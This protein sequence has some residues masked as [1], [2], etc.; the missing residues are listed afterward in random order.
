M[1]KVSSNWVKVNNERQLLNIPFTK[2]TNENFVNWD[3]RHYRLISK[4][5]YDVSKAGGDYIFAFFPLF[6]LVWRTTHLPPV[7]ILLLNYLLYA[8][9]LY[10]ILKLFSSDDLTSLILSFSIPGL[11]IFLIPYS[12]AVFFITVAVGFYGFIKKKYTIFFI[13]FFLAAIDRP[14]YTILAL[15]IV[16]VEFISLMHKGYYKKFI[17]NLSLRLLPL[18]AGTVFVS[19][20]QYFQGSGDFF[21]FIKVQK[22]WDNVLAIPHNIIDWSHEGF[23]INIGVITLIFLPLLAYLIITVYRK[24]SDSL[25]RNSTDSELNSLYYLTLLSTLYIIGSTLFIIFFRGGSL[26]CLFRFTI[27]TPFFPV[28]VISFSQML[29]KIEPQIRFFML[30]C[31]FLAGLF[32]LAMVDYSTYWSFA[33]LG[34]FIL[35]AT[36]T[37]WVFRKYQHKLIYKT[38]LYLNFFVNIIWTS[39]LF[40]AYIND[41]WIFA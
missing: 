21:R 23:G 7:G 35:T 32:I 9:G 25:S 27:C 34:F 24:V 18:I 16:C 1:G 26:H 3:A 11:V 28:V 8:A 14:A 37:L 29:H 19:L 6:P 2:L 13:G 4:H 38:F 31:L 17:G 10:L 36:I 15:A 22:Y 39:F 20:Y 40:N 33:D 30:A 12:E 41:A 5:G